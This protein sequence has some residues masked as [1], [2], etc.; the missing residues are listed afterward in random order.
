MGQQDSKASFSS[1]SK[2]ASTFGGGDQAREANAL[3][4]RLGKSWIN[5]VSTCSNYFGYVDCAD[6]VD[7]ADCA[8]GLAE[9]GCWCKAKGG[10]RRE[11]SSLE[12]FPLIEVKM[13]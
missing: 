7:Y 8:P 13:E 4:D 1:S 2:R 11:I 12:N 3:R 5:W 6:Y 9:A 10:R